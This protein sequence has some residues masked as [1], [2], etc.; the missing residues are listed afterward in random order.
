METHIYKILLPAEWADFQAKGVFIG[1]PIDLEDGYIHFSTAAQ[2]EET[3]RKHFSRQED[4]VLAEVDADKLGEVLKYEP[5]R[6]GDLFPHLYAPL[7]MDAVTRHWD[8][9]RGHDGDYVFPADI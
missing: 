6:G 3:A 8:L 2:M 7:S 4:L 1:A 9:K 5:S